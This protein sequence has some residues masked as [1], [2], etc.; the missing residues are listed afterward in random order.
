MQSLGKGMRETV[1]DVAGQQLRCLEGGEGPTILFLH[2]AGGASWTPLL[3]R[4]S[5]NWHVIAPEHPGFGRSVIPDWMMSVGDLAFFYLDVLKAMDLSG[6]NIVGHSLGGW[7][8]AEIAIRDTGRLRSLTLMAPAG[9]A[10][11]DAPFGDVFLWSPE[12][13][14]RRQFYNQELAEQRVRAQAAME[15]DVLLQNRAALARLAWSPRLHNPQLPFWLHRVDRPTL[16]VWGVD[17]QV[18]PYACHEPF[19]REIREAELFTLEQ[20]G[21]ALAVERPDETSSRLNAFLRGLPQ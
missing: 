20:T 1:I 19:M 6:V 2:G 10:V 5:A 11:A 21:H 4:L 18:V 17:D 9:V 14:A 8:A 3:E 12:E 16:L 13:G 7:T 15:I